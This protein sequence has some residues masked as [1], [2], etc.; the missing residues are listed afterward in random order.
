MEQMK[1]NGTLTKSAAA[2]QLGI[3]RGSV[4]RYAAKNPAVVDEAGRI[5]LPAIRRVIAKAK[6]ADKRGFPLG[7]PR[8]ALAASVAENRAARQEAWA[9]AS[10]RQQARLDRN[11]NFLL[12]PTVEAVR[13]AFDDWQASV[14][15]VSRRRG[16]AAWGAEDWRKTAEELRP[17]ADFYALCRRNSQP[18]ASRSAIS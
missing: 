1:S 9:K 16:R 4:L 11:R 7:R 3:S 18:K 15:D 12:W 6:A 5:K 17:V 8:E 2:R 13:R 14:G 10:R